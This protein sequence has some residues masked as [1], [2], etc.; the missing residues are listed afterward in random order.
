M[1]KPYIKKFRVIPPFTVWIVDGE[2]IR[3]N[4]NEEFTNFGDHYQFNFIPKNEFWIDRER[5]PGEEKYY[6]DSMLVMNRLMAKGVNRKE[7]IKKA[8]AVERKERANSRLMRKEIE[9]KRSEKTFLSS[10][11]KNLLKKYSTNKLKIWVV[12]GE[13]VRDLFFLD[14]TEG[15]HGYVYPFIPQDEV[16]IDDD[17][18]PDEIKFVLLH[19]LHERNLMKKGWC[20][21]TDTPDNLKTGKIRKSAHRSSSKI[22]YY[23]R[24]HAKETDKKIKEEIRKNSS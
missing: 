18:E 3:N 21:D 15:G 4:I 7:A 23:C 6:I 1:K 14:F 11:H 13:K 9:F 22:E 10:V 5:V 20:Y 8:D 19:E 16:W 24:F 17:V 2:Y 12:S